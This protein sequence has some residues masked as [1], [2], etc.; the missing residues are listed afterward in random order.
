MHNKVAVVILNYNNLSFLQKFLHDIV[1]H[2]A[3]HQVYIADNGSSDE[4]VAFVRANFPSVPVIENNGNFG[5]AEGYNLA[6]KQVQ[7][8]FYVLLNSDV[9]VTANW[10][11]PVIQLMESDPT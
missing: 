10:I 8:E 2:S 7:S 3:P 11:E 6:L 9:E 5:Y 4:S 1:R